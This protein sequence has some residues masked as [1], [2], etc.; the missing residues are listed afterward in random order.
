MSWRMVART[1]ATKGSD[2]G[3]PIR[4]FRVQWLFPSIGCQAGL[5]FSVRLGGQS[6]CYMSIHFRLYSSCFKL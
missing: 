2:L 4:L 3:T 1:Y 5:L 6:F